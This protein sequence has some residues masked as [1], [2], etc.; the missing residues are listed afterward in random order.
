M[1]KA[2]KKYVSP[3]IEELNEEIVAGGTCGNCDNTN[4]GLR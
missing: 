2:K 4:T 1:K 3:K